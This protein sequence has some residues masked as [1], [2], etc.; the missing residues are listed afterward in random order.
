MDRYAALPSLHFGW[1]LLVGLTLARFHPRAAVRIARRADAGRDGARGRD[2]GQPLRPRRHRRRHRR[3][4][5]AR[6]REPAHPRRSTGARGSP[7]TPS[8]TARRGDAPL[9][10]A[11]RAGNDPAHLRAAEEAG[12]DV[13]EADLHLWRGRLELRHLKTVGPL[14]LYWDRWAL[15][16]PWRRFDSSTT[17]S[18]RA[19]P[20]TSLMLDLKGRDPAAAQLL[21]PSSAGPRAARP[22]SSP[23]ARGRCSTRSIRRS[24]SGS[25]RPRGRVSS[26]R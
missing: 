6:D 24:R 23:R 1:D 16:P 8:A 5:G 17:C 7:R 12:A 9:L 22:C 14:P 10:I 18:P 13:I 15:A 19:R 20:Q 3:D 21:S 4:D 11:H 25:A 26:T 2:D